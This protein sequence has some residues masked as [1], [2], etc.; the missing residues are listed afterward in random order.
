MP[1]SEREEH[2]ASLNT[3]ITKKQRIVKQKVSVP[4]AGVFGLSLMVA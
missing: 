1:I 3:F 2:M 4:E